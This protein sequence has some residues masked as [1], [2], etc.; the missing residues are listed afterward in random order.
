[1]E[2]TSFNVEKSDLK[3]KEQN[4]INA[5]SKEQEQVKELL[6]RGSVRHY[7]LG[8]ESVW[9]Q[10]GFG[11]VM[12]GIFC[13]IIG[14][15]LLPKLLLYSNTNIAIKYMCW[16]MTAAGILLIAKG[17]YGMIKESRKERKP[18]P[19]KV[20]DEILEYDI[21]GLKD[22]SKVLLKTNI[23]KLR[24]EED[25][26][27][28]EMVLVRG[29]IDYVENVNLPLL[30]KLGDDGK[31][32][33][34]NS[35][36]MAIY[37]GKDSLYI[38]TSIYNMRNGTSKFQH[39][40]ECLYNKIKFVGFQDRVIETVTQKNKAVTQNLQMFVINAG[41]EEGSEL[42]LTVKDYDVIKSYKGLLDISDAEMAE[43]IILDKIKE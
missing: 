41:D 8:P 7:Y 3:D 43:K 14:S 10:E 9:T 39:T 35:S 33:Y 4:H 11:T 38:Y 16:I 15:V 21:E 42:A 2:K 24:A 31:L 5:V 32:R 23:P 29:P 22:K 36:V 19:D 34:S 20:H 13:T 12:G 6:R 30:W 27:K 1:M 40:Y 26:E 28:M 17:L 18:V 37:F 25:I